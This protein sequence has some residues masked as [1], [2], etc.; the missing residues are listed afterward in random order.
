MKIGYSVE[1]STDRALLEGLRRRWCQ[2][3]EPVQGGFR[4]RSGLSRSREIPTICA[5]LN[6]KGVDLIIFL[7]DANDEDWRKV[8][9]ADAKC[10]R[11][12][13]EHLTVFGVCNRN[14][15]SWI[16]SDADWLARKTGQ[17]SSG[18]RVADPKTA[19]ESALGVTPRNRK[20][21]EIAELIRE[22]PLVNWL[23]NKSFKTFYGTL[24]QKSKH[25]HCTIENLRDRQSGIT[26]RSR[27]RGRKPE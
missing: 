11:P 2:H 6:S 13:F 23:P 17:Q 24:W 7:R 26:H 14:V 12:E 20:E 16:C 10:C 9:R 22:A 19:F 27:S 8:L 4:G 21:N 1:G 3:A 25:L 5:E 18:F 15:E